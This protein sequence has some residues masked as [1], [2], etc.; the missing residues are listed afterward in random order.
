M[1]ARTSPKPLF[2]STPFARPIGG[3]PRSV[4]G[5]T[6]EDLRAFHRTHH[7]RGNVAVL[8]LGADDCAATMARLKPQL[9]GFAAGD[10]AKIPPFSRSHP[11]A[12]RLPGEGFEAG[13]F[14]YDANEADALMMKV[15]AKHLEQRA[16][17]ELR[18]Q[19]GLTYTPR[20]TYV[21]LGRAGLIAI[22]VKTSGASSQV[23]RWYDRTV[24]ELR[25]STEP[26][27]LLSEA[28]D[29]VRRTFDT[30]TA[31]DALARIRDQRAPRELL[32][33]LE[34][35]QFRRRLA[36][37]IAPDRGFGSSQKNLVE[38]LVLVACGA[39]IVAFIGWLGRSLL[40]G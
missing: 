6:L 12:T 17:E 40:R 22:T 30:V 36:R 10:A 23:S 27:T 20:S 5:L 9:E 21:G 35:P 13:F 3:T 8:L 2:G 15:V 32:R 28:I 33:T 25:E 11:G 19:E 26:A 39:G 14:W 18:K 7:V 31:A 29:Q 1:R 16:L 38:V 24:A 34:G 37:M 4:G